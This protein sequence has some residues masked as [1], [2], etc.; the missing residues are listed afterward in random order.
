MVR[1]CFPGLSGDDPG[2]H[3]A[4]VD[5]GAVVVSH[6]NRLPCVT[7]MMLLESREMNSVSTEGEFSKGSR[8]SFI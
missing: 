3:A 7:A 4:R 5:A 6:G 2:S 8:T 1:E